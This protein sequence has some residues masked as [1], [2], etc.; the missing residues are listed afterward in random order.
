MV[1]AIQII[2]VLLMLFQIKNFWLLSPMWFVILLSTNFFGLL[3]KYF[4]FIGTYNLTPQISIILLFFQVIIILFKQKKIK[5]NLIPNFSSL[6]TL[7]SLFFIIQTISLI[8]T[9]ISGYNPLES[10]LFPY[11]EFIPYIFIPLLYLIFR[12]LDSKLVYKTWKLILDLTILNTIIYVL[13][14]LGIL[15][16]YGEGVFIKIIDTDLERTLQGFPVF[17]FFLLIENYLSLRKKVTFKNSMILFLIFLAILLSL[18][19][20]LLLV[21]LFITLF[22]EIIYL[23]SSNIKIIIKQISLGFI[24]LMILTLIAPSYFNAFTSRILEVTESKAIFNVNNFNSSRHILAK[25]I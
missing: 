21:F 8:I 5:K 19:R 11:L 14:S 25:F 22:S 7:I 24:A 4:F 13:N 17:I 3:S 1:Q 6:V 12:K 2:G 23:K 10:F 15:N 20:S 18:T 9:F 16:F